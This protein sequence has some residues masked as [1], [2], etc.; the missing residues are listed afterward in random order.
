[1]V[2]WVISTWNPG[3]GSCCPSSSTETAFRPRSFQEFQYSSSLFRLEGVCFGANTLGFETYIAESA[4]ESPDCKAFRQVS[5]CNTGEFAACARM[6]V[7][8]DAAK[9][10]NR[11][12]FEK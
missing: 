1:M 5:S 9:T 11:K 10:S 12:T 3:C 6:T 2:N 4:A 8:V 7:A